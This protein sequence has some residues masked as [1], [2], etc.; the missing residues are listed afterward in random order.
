MTL[1]PADKLRAILTRRYDYVQ[2][3]TY[4]TLCKQE[5]D[6]CHCVS[7]GLVLLDAM[8]TGIDRLRAVIRQTHIAACCPDPVSGHSVHL[9]GCK[10]YEIEP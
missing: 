6:E 3:A 5:P 1:T 7:D 8:G 10:L 9:P 2:G 4:C